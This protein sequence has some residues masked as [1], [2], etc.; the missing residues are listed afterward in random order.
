MITTVVI[1][2]DR[3]AS[4][5]RIFLAGG[6]GVL[7]REVIPLLTAAGHEVAATTRTESKA[8]LLTGL[9]ATP[10]VVDALDRDAVLEAMGQARPEAVLH[11]LTDLG[12]G[13]SA[14]N[15]RLRTVGTRHLV[16]AALRHGVTRMV[17]ES[18]SW[19]Y[20]P[21]SA[22]ATEDDRLDLD[23][24]EPRRTTVTAVHALESAVRELPD[25]VV[26]RLGQLYGPGTW[27]A[28]QGRFGQDARDSR[29]T[30]ADAVTSFVHVADAARAAS[31]A[32][33]WPAGVWNVVD[34][35]PAPG[36]A[37][38]PVF[39]AAV[40][41]PAPAVAFTGDLGR[42]VSNA[43]AGRQGLE[44]RHPSWRDGFATL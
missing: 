4:P 44:L 42:P 39:A 40:G 11:L 3:K 9:G 24:A 27:Y 2:P 34:D 23:A 30:V 37:W 5:M 21:G 16:D 36:H 6:S 22:A 33:A 17:A 35:E 14:S 43:R 8:E 38:A 26:L 13:D 29:L 1:V 20:E 25:G 10:V 15:A 7:G 18:I 28:R 12:S 19:V 32:L 41:A 31:R